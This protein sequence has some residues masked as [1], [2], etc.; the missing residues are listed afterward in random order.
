M[1]KRI[2]KILKVIGVAFIILVISVIV[3]FICH[4]VVDNIPI[5][6]MLIVIIFAGAFANFIVS[7]LE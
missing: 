7:Q 4:I 1:K 6:A 3:S 5:V 2:K